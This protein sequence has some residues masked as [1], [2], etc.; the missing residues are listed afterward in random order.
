MILEQINCQYSLKNKPQLV[1][2][3]HFDISKPKFKSYY[4]LQF[5]VRNLNLQNFINIV[6]PF[7]INS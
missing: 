1:N 6:V 7:A 4:Q 5:S 2:R 3:G